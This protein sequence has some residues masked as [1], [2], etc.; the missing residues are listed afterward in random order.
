MELKNIRK[1]MIVFGS[2]VMVLVVTAFFSAANLNRSTQLTIDLIGLQEVNQA[3]NKI[4]TALD[5][6][7]IAIGQYQLSGDEETL[8][9]FENAQTEYEETGILL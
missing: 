2:V 5:E 3:S 4:I 6:E 7:R 8:N 9:R 1:F